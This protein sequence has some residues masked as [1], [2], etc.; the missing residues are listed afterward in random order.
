MRVFSERTPTSSSYYTR[1]VVLEVFVCDEK[2]ETCVGYQCVSMCLE[3]WSEIVTVNRFVDVLN[4]FVQKVSFKKTS[5]NAVCR[6]RTPCVG[7]PSSSR[8]LHCWLHHNG[9]TDNNTYQSILRCES[10]FKKSHSWRW[11]ARFELVVIAQPTQF[12]FSK[13]VLCNSNTNLCT[14]LDTVCVLVFEKIY[15]DRGRERSHSFCLQKVP[16]VSKKESRV[17]ERFLHRNYW[18]RGLMILGH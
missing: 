16:I 17:N 8:I 6:I 9:S 2:G 10:L 11:Y 7:T 14:P 1:A 15:Q 18:F 13:G 3:G 12:S 4:L 5:A